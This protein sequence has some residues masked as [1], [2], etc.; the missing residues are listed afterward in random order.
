ML[1]Y[2]DE[3]YDSNKDFLILGALFNPEPK[4]VHSAM[5]K[6]KRDRHHVDASGQPREIKYS[7]SGNRRRYE[8]ARECVNCFGSSQSWFRAIVIETRRGTFDLSYFGHAFEA[9]AMKWARAYKRFG[10]MLLSNNSANIENGV[11]LTDRLTRTRGDLF[12]E[13]MREGFSRPG[14]A[15]STGKARPTFRHIQEVDTALPAYQVGQ[16]GDILMGTILNALKP[17]VNEYKTRL[18]AHVTR[19]LSLPSL[20]PAYWQQLSKWQ[21]EAVH[22]KFGIWYWRPTQAK[23]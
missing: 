20:Q 22:P 18:R 7:I 11:L 8:V 3:S 23:V 13:L 2:F 21:A 12:L 15:F 5:L 19:T 1:V 6:V 17:T 16:I 10:E 4:A 9:D 14:I